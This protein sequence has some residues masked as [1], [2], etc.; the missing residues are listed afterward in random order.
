MLDYGADVLKSGFSFRNNIRLNF[1]LLDGFV[2]IIEIESALYK[3]QLYLDKFA[4]VFRFIF[5]KILL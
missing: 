2:R 5:T 3:L 1:D 4:F